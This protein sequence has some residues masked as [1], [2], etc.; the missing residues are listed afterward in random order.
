MRGAGAIASSQM[1]D[2]SWK[3]IATR[4]DP[5]RHPGGDH[6]AGSTQSEIGARARDEADVPCDRDRFR[7][8]DAY[9]GLRVV[10]TRNRVHPAD[11]LRNSDCQGRSF[12]GIPTNSGREMVRSL[13]SKTGAISHFDT[14]DRAH[15][16]KGRKPRVGDAAKIQRRSKRPGTLP[17][18]GKRGNKYRRIAKLGQPGK[19]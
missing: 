4:E 13:L 15:E 5:R 14:I 11:S 1:S 2:P 10:L 9:R 7:V 19:I 16:R 3:I 12:N 6:I 18:G 8:S 17:V